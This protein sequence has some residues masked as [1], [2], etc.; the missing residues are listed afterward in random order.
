MR[1]FA[2]ISLLACQFAAAAPESYIEEFQIAQG[3]EA[4]DTLG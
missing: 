4:A 1:W 3:L 2:I